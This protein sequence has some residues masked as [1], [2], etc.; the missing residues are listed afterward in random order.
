[1]RSAECVFSGA[2]A[3]RL[4]VNRAS[5]PAASLRPGPE[6]FRGQNPPGETPVLHAL[7]AYKQAEFPNNL[8]DRAEVRPEGPSMK[9]LLVR[10][11]GMITPNFAL[12][13]DLLQ[14]ALIHLW[15]TETRRPGQTR[16][17]YLQSSKFHLQHY[18]ASGCSVDSPKRGRGHSHIDVNSEQAEELPAL[19]DPGDSVSSQVSARDIISLLSPHLSPCELAVLDGL[20]DGLGVREIGRRLGMSHA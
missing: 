11:I 18:L 14:E 5:S 20:A 19:V 7:N 8:D 1:M 2:Q 12:R 13:E 16:S 4:R 9:D 17:W 10:M 3:S 6:G 15:L